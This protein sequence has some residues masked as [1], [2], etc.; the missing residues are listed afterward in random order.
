MA[1]ITLTKWKLKGLFQTYQYILG[2]SWNL[3]AYKD[4][5][6]VININNCARHNAEQV[7]LKGNMLNQGAPHKNYDG[8]LYNEHVNRRV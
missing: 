6:G 3:R 4:N 1:K 7:A 2:V 5:F 8:D